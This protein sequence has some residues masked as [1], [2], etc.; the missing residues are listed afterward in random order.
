[1][2]NNLEKFGFTK[3]YNGG[4]LCD[5]YMVIKS[6]NFLK[7]HIDTDKHKKYLE[8]R[9]KLDS[10]FITRNEEYGSFKCGCLDTNT[11]IYSKGFYKILN[12]HMESKK[13]LDY[14]ESKKTLKYQLQQIQN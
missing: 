3:N 10:N 11:F 12:R 4:Y 7:K 14:M 13:H 9:K 2:E 6:R 5:C 1:M 8:F